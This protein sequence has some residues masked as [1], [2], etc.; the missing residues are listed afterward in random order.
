[1][2]EATEREIYLRILEMLDDWANTEKYIL[3]SLVVKNAIKFCH[4]YL[5][6]RVRVH[7]LNFIHNSKPN[8]DISENFEEKSKLYNFIVR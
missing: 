7:F 3:F 6:Q 1:M 5:L 4:F 8:W 2:T